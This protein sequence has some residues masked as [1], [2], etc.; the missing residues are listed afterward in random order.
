MKK[1]HLTALF[2]ILAIAFVWG[3]S[4]SFATWGNNARGAY[5]IDIDDFPWTDL[6]PHHTEFESRG[7]PATLAIIAGQCNNANWDSLRVYHEFG[8]E[9]ANHTWNHSGTAPNW[10]ANQWALNVDSAQVKI[11]REI[12]VR[13]YWYVYPEDVFDDETNDVIRDKGY[14]GA[15]AGPI[16]DAGTYNPSD[17]PDGIETGFLCM[18]DDF[19]NTQQATIDECTRQFNSYL[20]N[21]YNYRRWGVRM[22][23]GIEDN[24]W[25][26]VPLEAFQNHLDRIVEMRDAGQIWVETCSNVYRYIRESNDHT[27]AVGSS[28]ETSTTL[29][30]TLDADL[31]TSIYNYPL[32]VLFVPPA[33]YADMEVE[34]NGESITFTEPNDSTI[35]FNANPNLGDIT[36]TN[37]GGSPAVQPVTMSLDQSGMILS[38][39]PNPFS[40]S[41]EI[42]YSAYNRNTPVTLSIYNA[43]GAMVNTLAKE[44]ITGMQIVKWNGTDAHGRNL[45]NGLYFCKLIAGTHTRTQRII[46][47]R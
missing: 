34:Q 39:T 22:M 5:S 4:V 17:L 3:Q 26:E 1:S 33:Y 6:V 16:M 25:G 42:R 31:D 24:D 28:D 43:A 15:C 23:H 29:E 41:V 10:N 19:K 36:V 47:M 9:I 14:I 32:T 11:E 30:F 12:G 35:Q 18:E 13:P 7:I 20:Q 38:G 45:P 40:N 21:C 8:H 44:S 27:I 2:C 37:N 46:L